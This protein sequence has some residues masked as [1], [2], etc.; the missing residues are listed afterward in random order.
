MGAGAAKGSP[1]PA[2]SLAHRESD[3]ADVRLGGREI[4]EENVAGARQ[5]VH[6][7]EEDEEEDLD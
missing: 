3:S 4:M 5:S 1:T 6:E 7:E 2:V